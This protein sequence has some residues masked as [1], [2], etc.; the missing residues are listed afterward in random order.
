MAGTDLGN[1]RMDAF[2]ELIRTVENKGVTGPEIYRRSF[3]KN[4]YFMDT[5]DHPRKSYTSGHHQSDAA[6][7]YG[8][9]SETYDWVKGKVHV[10]D[11]SPES[12][13]KIARWLIQHKGA[14]TYITHG[15][16]DSAYSSLNGTWS[17]LPHG[18]AQQITAEDANKFING[19]VTQ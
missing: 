4:H 6:G 12:Q 9:K 10:H 3:G 2:L 16:Y 5:S 17:S 11:F 7:A 19:K 14:A 8:I 1:K 15:N 13:D 18:T